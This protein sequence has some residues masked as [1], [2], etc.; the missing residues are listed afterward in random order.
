MWHT[1]SWNSLRSYFLFKFYLLIWWKLV[2]AIQFE[3]RQI[4]TILKFLLGSFHFRFW[5]LSK[6][7]KNQKNQLL[8]SD[9]LGIP[10]LESKQTG[11]L[12]F[13]FLVTLT[14]SKKR[15]ESDI[16]L[17]FTCW[18]HFTL[19]LH[20]MVF[21]AL[22]FLNYYIFQIAWISF[23]FHFIGEFMQ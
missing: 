8:F 18:H 22:R 5:F 20:H 12:I 13:S 1:D 19:N 21:V 15:S 14:R 9:K 10:F 17:I 4:R 3:F 2:F 7:T 6:V 16:W 11:Q 23:F